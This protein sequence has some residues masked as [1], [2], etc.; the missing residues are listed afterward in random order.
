MTRAERITSVD[1]ALHFARKRL[2]AG[3]MQTFENGAGELKTHDAN[4]RA[5]DAVQFRPRHGIYHARR[6]I[7]T[8]VL[9]HQLRTPLIASSIGALGLAH[10]DGEAGVAR[11]ASAAGG[12]TFVSGFTSQPIEEIVAAS[13]A[14]VYFQLYYFGAGRE[15]MS[16]TIERA[17]DAGCAGLVFVIDSVIGHTP[18]RALPVGS[19]RF[20]PGEASLRDTLLFAPQL[21]TRPGWVL[22]YLRGRVPDR[23]PMALDADGV[24]MPFAQARAHAYDQW[25]DWKDL[26][27]IRDVWDCPIVV[28]GALS[29][30]DAR[31]AVDHGAVGVVVSNHGGNRLDGTIP[32]LPVLPEVVEAVGDQIDVLYDSGI[33]TGPDVVKALALGAKAVGLGRAYLYPLAAAGEAGVRRIFEI[34]ARDIDHTLA[35][36]GCQTLDELGPEHLELPPGYRTASG[37]TG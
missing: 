4:L 29:V 12:I 21:V 24:E 20:L 35:Y 10:P 26:E 8:T 36:L 23:A 13:S 27:W 2:P 1:D 15:G 17:R 31:H 3:I 5:L 37:A 9:G 25:T 28:K 16:A 22:D 11:A 34:F 18:P 33:R 32:A 30:D 19:R 6:D 7:G 14:P